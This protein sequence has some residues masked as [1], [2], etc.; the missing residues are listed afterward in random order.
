MVEFNAV[1]AVLM[2]EEGECAT[3]ITPEIEEGLTALGLLELLDLGRETCS[4]DEQ[5]IGFVLTQVKATE[6]AHALS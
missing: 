1:L 3:R 2:T 6:L 4:S 5:V